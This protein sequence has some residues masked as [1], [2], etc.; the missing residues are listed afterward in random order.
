MG[1]FVMCR[2]LKIDPAAPLMRGVAPLAL[3][4]VF[5]LAGCATL[6]DRSNVGA[7]TNAGA[8]VGDALRAGRIVLLGEVHDNAALHRERQRIVEAALAAGARP[9]FVFEQ[10]DREAQP[11]ID[12]A[13]RERPRDAEHLIAQAKPA[14]GSWNWDFYRPLIQLALDRDLPIV[15]GNLSRNDAMKLAQGAADPATNPLPTSIPP[16]VTAAQQQ[17]VRTGHCNLLPDAALA[18][19]A[20]AQIARDATMAKQIEAV[21]QVANAKGVLLFAGNGHVRRDVGV[22]VW[23]KPGAGVDA[24]VLTVGFLETDA[25]SNTAITRDSRFDSIVYGSPA[26]RPDP[27]VALKA[28]FAK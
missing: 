3:A 19:M 17:E 18:P 11:A 20:Q 5:A 4:V 13:R 16:A 27:C 2:M 25:T 21:S 24:T 26:E 10:F 1:F 14:R 15:A 28:R 7:V 9:A 8:S 23:L 6:P 22:P 12:A